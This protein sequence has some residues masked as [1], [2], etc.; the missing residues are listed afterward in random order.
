MTEEQKAAYL[1]MCP[2][3]FVRALRDPIG[4]DT[5][6]ELSEGQATALLRARE[7]ADGWRPIETAPKDG[8][9][10]LAWVPDGRMMIWR[11]DLLA[12]GLSARTPEHLKFPATHWRPLP[13][14]PEKKEK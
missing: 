14:P 11:A 10:I 12:H 7:N 8:T 3:V 4:A 13:A 9:L 1:A 2:R 6:F 5:E